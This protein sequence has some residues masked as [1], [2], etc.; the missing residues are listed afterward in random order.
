MLN[1]YSNI[2]DLI[3]IFGDVGNFVRTG[4]GADFVYFCD[5]VAHGEKKR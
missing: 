3:I 2:L 4:I 1:L 5:I